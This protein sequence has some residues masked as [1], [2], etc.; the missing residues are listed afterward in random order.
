MNNLHMNN[1]NFK[2]PLSFRHVPRYQYDGDGRFPHNKIKGADKRY[3]RK[4]QIKM[5]IKE[6]EKE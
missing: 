4:R 3:L 5:Y 1:S 2:I 6:Y